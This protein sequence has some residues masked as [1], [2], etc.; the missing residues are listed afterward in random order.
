MLAVLEPGE[1]QLRVAIERD[2]L[3]HV[4]YEDVTPA[5]LS[6]LRVTR[7]PDRSRPRVAFGAVALER[8]PIPI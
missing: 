8:P 3:G 6:T 7:L 2:L 5:G 4:R 1:Y